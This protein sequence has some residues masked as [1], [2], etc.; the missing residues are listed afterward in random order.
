MSP[1]SGVISKWLRNLQKCE[2]FIIYG[3]EEQIRDFVYIKDVVEAN[4]KAAITKNV[5]SE[6]FNIGSDTKITI[7][8]LANTM[9]VLFFL[10]IK[11]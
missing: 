7:N 4:F 1:N 2:N 9:K 6:V 8:D 3:D 11:L 5:A 10:I